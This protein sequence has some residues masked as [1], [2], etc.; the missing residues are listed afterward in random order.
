MPCSRRFWVLAVLAA[1]GWALPLSAGTTEDLESP[2]VETRLSAA[3]SVSVTT[4]W[5][6]LSALEHRMND[7]NED[8]RVRLQAARALLAS[9][10]PGQSAQMEVALSIAAS[11]EV[12]GA[13]GVAAA[14]LGGEGNDALGP[15]TAWHDR[16]EVDDKFFRSVLSRIGTPEARAKLMDNYQTESDR[17]HVSNPS[18]FTTRTSSWYRD[19]SRNPDLDQS[20]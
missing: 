20:R 2:A 15:L 19:R 6:V 8:P 9:N 10:Y 3:S 17:N 4:D 11:K 14:A 5:T 1:A 13:E 7:F 12:D 16:G 18:A